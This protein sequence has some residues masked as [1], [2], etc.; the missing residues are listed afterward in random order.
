MRTLKSIVLHP[1][2][3]NEHRAEVE[4]W[5]KKN[6]E[7]GWTMNSNYDDHGTFN[8]TF[9]NEKTSTLSSIFMIK[10]PDTKILKEE[11]EET[12]EVADEALALFD[13]E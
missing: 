12:Y 3:E 7:D 9:H 13:W 4:S 8:I 2:L 11:W 10:Y 6:S 5:L 1:K